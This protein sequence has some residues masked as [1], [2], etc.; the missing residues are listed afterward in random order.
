[1]PKEGIKFEDFLMNVDPVNL[2]FINETHEFML[3]KNCSYK[4]ET[5][6]NGYVFSYTLPKT[7]K[8]IA[9]YVF[10]K[11]GMIIRIYGD[12]IEHPKRTA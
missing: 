5:A 9:N 12:N 1:M 2:G 6:K 10:R 4:I 7:K 11:N 8:V 3:N